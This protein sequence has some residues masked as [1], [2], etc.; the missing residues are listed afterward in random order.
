MKFNVVVRVRRVIL[1]V[2]KQDE[3]RNGRRGNAARRGS[4]RL[5]CAVIKVHAP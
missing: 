1:T 5:G 4:A 3:A 2:L